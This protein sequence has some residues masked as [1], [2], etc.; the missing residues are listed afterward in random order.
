MPDEV[1]TNGLS[2]DEAKTKKFVDLVKGGEA[3]KDAAKEVGM[4]LRRLR[5][6]GVLATACRE[7]LGRVESEKLL[8]KKTAEMITRARLLELM[9]QDDDLKVALGAAK[10]VVESHRP[11]MAVQIN[12]NLI[13][14][15]G[16]VESLK[17]LQIDVEA[18]EVEE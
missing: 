13:T 10:A 4:S 16:V 11:G 2:V 3:P 1:T 17:S 15:P 7:L 9:M 6:T 14:D 8:D 18:Q 5:E 12:N